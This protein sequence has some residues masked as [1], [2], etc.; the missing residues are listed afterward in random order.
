ME[1]GLFVT[2]QQGATYADQLAAALTAEAAGFRSFVRSDH[3]LANG[4]DIRLPGPTDTWITLAGL[5]RET[6]TIELGVM[7]SAAT[8]RPPG[9]MSI[10]AAQVDEMADGRLVFGLGTGWN[11]R[12]HE[13]LGLHFPPLAER[14]ER[15]EEQL[16]I[17]TGLWA[18]PVG[19][20]YTF[21]GRHYGLDSAPGLPKPRRAPGPYLVVGGLGAVRTPTLA[22]RFADEFNLPPF[23]TPEQAGVAF[24]RVRARCAAVG[25]D[26]ATLATSLTLTTFCGRDHGELERRAACAPW[27]AAHASLRGTPAEVVDALAAFESTGATRAYLRVLDVRDLDHIEL[28]AGTLE[29][30]G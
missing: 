4:N 5:A 1:I 11:Q 18:T 30:G 16:E 22:A 25:R 7:V 24:A 3:Y 27:D 9:P 2:P 26:P 12:E 17:I 14:F 10:V 15:L 20:T 21:H 29:L 28:L 13:A 19:E 6:T 8:F 23:Q